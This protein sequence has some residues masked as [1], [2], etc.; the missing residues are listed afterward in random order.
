MQIKVE[1]TRHYGKVSHG[2]AVIVASDEYEGATVKDL[3]TTGFA[4]LDAMFE[5]FETNMLPKIQYKQAEQPSNAGV[6]GSKD[7]WNEIIEIMKEV[8]DGKESI[9]LRTKPGSYFNKYG[10]A[11]Y[12]ECIGY[13]QIVNALGTGYSAKPP[14]GITWKARLQTEGS[15]KA[16]EFMADIPL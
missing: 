8:K 4:M 15:K 9:R 11:V 12:P 2:F 5:D 14:S 3:Y 13:E 1:Q 10:V 6:F 7:D 16:L